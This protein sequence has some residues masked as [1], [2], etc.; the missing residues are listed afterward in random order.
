MRIPMTIKPIYLLKSGDF[1]K[2]YI[3][4]LKLSFIER[5]EQ[6]NYEDVKVS[7]FVITPSSMLLSLVAKSYLEERYETIT[8]KDTEIRLQF[9]CE[10]FG[11]TSVCGSLSLVS[12][13]LSKLIL[14]YDTMSRCS[15][16]YKFL[17]LGCVTIDEMLEEKENEGFQRLIENVFSCSSEYAISML[18]LAKER[19]LKTGSYYDDYS[20]MVYVLRGSL[21]ERDEQ[22]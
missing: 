6:G 12:Y 20:D 16:V 15:R 17:S 19:L 5:V 22:N 7:D 10:D 18:E 3:E 4:Y 21:H 14:F 9:D 13:D 11:I 8:I 1:G 2:L